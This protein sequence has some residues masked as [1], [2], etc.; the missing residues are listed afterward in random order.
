M[1]RFLARAAL[2]C[3]VAAHAGHA[4]YAAKKVVVTGIPQDAERVVGGKCIAPW[5]CET[6]KN[7]GVFQYQYNI[8]GNPKFKPGTVRLRQGG[9]VA[10]Q[11]AL[12]QRRHK[13]SFVKHFALLIPEGEQDAVYIEPGYAIL[14]TQQDKKAANVYDAYGDIFLERILS[15]PVRLSYNPVEWASRKVVD[16]LPPGAVDAVAGEVATREIESAIKDGRD[17]QEVQQSGT[18]SQALRGILSGLEVRDPQYLVYDENS[19]TTTLAT[20]DTY[21]A[22]LGEL[23]AGCEAADPKQIQSLVGSYNKIVKAIEYLNTTC[24]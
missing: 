8:Y 20:K 24:R 14:L 19:E 10:G 11:I 22:V 3:L 15:G 12:M 16:F 13:V 17:L 18:A 5:L 1:K 7:P 21:A 6:K 2:L 4:A 9:E 23:F